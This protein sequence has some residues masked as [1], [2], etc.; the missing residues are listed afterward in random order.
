ML[1]RA[2]GVLGHQKRFLRDHKT[3]LE[4]WSSDV[5][6]LRLAT[7]DFVA[8]DKVNRAT[9]EAD[10]PRLS[11]P[12]QRDPR[13]RPGAGRTRLREIR[14]SVKCKGADKRRVDKL[15]LAH[16]D[17]TW[18]PQQPK[19]VDGNKR[20]KPCVSEKPPKR[21]KA[22]VAKIEPIIEVEVASIGNVAEA[23]AEDIAEDEEMDDADAAATDVPDSPGQIWT[24]LEDNSY[25]SPISRRQPL[26]EDLTL[27]ADCRLGQSSF[28]PL[29][30]SGSTPKLTA[31]LGM[32]YNVHGWRDVIVYI[33]VSRPLEYQK[34]ARSTLPQTVVHTKCSLPRCSWL[35]VTWCNLCETGARCDGFESGQDVL[36]QR[37]VSALVV[38]GKAHSTAHRGKGDATPSKPDPRLRWRRLGPDVPHILDVTKLSVEQRV[39]VQLNSVG[40]IDSTYTS[41]GQVR[42]RRDC[43]VCFVE[44]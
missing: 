23:I 1:Q 11:E 42:V 43:C 7:E 25:F 3:S 19:P 6:G 40:L 4:K 37:L 27:E 29:R 2:L 36:R 34:L 8:D 5:Y 35:H 14:V 16:V 41:D 33:C 39:L 13:E 15:L 10:A 26:P 31:D 22:S 20:S 44:R 24:W 21:V 12:K 28:V 32:L 30:P 18:R 17:H 38:P 9:V